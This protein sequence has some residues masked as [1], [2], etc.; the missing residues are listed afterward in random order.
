MSMR[1][2]SISALA[3]VACATGLVAARDLARVDEYVR[4]EMTRQKIPGLAVAIVENGE[5]VKAQGYG[6]S[7]VEHGVPVSADTIFQS[8]SVG[9]QFTAAAVM[10]LVED[11][12][13][14]LTD[15]IAKYF[16]AAPKAWKNVTIRHLL[17]HTSGLP[18]YTGGMVDYR[19]DYTEEQLLRL[20][21]SLRL[22]FSP[23]SRWNYSN[24][25][26]VLL[27]AIIRKASGRFYGDLLRERLFEPLGMK[28]ARVISE[29]DIV[30]HRAAG[31]RLVS[32]T[33]KNQDWV[34][35]SL[36]TTADGALYFSLRDLVAWDRGI[37][38][39]RVLTRESWTQIFTPVTLNSGRT[40]PY[41][42]GWAIEPVNG[43]P[44]HM[45][46]GSWQGFQT[47]IVRYPD[48]RLTIAVLSNLAQSNPGQIAEGISALL[49]PSL[50]RPGLK[51]IAER[52]PAI[53]ARVRQIL[54][55]AATGNLKPEEFAYVRAGFFPGAPERYAKLLAHAG[56][57]QELTLMQAAER[58]DDRMYV[59]DVTFSSTTLRLRLGLAPDGKI[60]AFDLRPRQEEGR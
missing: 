33:L 44:A 45:H 8:G 14:S 6:E 26:Y 32:G 3:I 34:S 47:F 22:E 50:A 46:G 27:G 39:G 12:K 28:T 2:R 20:A 9:K 58:G 38:E 11:G 7:N 48:D 36:N 15:P 17:T 10:L 23:G 21:Y 55:A 19:K 35:P 43:H 5:V 25:G 56:A 51:P 29:A 24:T 4:A 42:F 37:R 18:D 57:I 41:G 13:L 60:A 53:D 30:P 16:D 49:E 1:C 54:A 59:Y 40:Y 52:D 31:Y